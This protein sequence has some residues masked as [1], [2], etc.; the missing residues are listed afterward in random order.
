M[1]HALRLG[2]GGRRKSVYPALK[3]AVARARPCRSAQEPT[4]PMCPVRRARKTT[5]TTAAAAWHLWP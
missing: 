1:T 3:R 2:K 5:H 4:T